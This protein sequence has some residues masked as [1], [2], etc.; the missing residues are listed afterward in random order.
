MRARAKQ[1][2]APWKKKKGVKRGF[3]III[4]IIIIDMITI[5]SKIDSQS[6]LLRA[7]LNAA[8]WN[9]TRTLSVL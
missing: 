6:A 8:P 2:A 3:I 7:K 5:I 4:I 9:K 1:N